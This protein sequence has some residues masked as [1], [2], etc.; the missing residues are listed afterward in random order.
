[1]CFGGTCVG[2]I[3]DLYM[4]TFM[5]VLVMELKNMKVGSA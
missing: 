5:V 2:L 1:M 4:V 3:Y